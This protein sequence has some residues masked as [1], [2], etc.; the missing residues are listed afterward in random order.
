MEKLSTS[1]SDKSSTTDEDLKKIKESK[2]DN[3]C[4]SCDR[5][6]SQAG[7][8]KTHIY[9]IH[10]GHKDHKCESCGKS[11]SEAGSL[12]KHICTIHMKRKLHKKNTINVI[13]RKIDN[14]NKQDTI[15]KECML[16]ERI[17]AR[18]E[19]SI[20]DLLVSA[21]GPPPPLIPNDNN[22][23]IFQCIKTEIIEQNSDKTEE[24]QSDLDF[25]CENDLDL[26]LHDLYFKPIKNEMIE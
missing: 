4:G 8:L 22:P 7:H 1:S 21:L 25:L 15:K 17:K 5:S 16:M 23:R 10:K 26:D 24:S 3:K 18:E 12:K 11:F 20:E 6:F 14:H 2:K 13:S 9:T 19:K